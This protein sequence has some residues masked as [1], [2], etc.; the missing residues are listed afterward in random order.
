MAGGRTEVHLDTK[1]L[2]LLQKT[3][4]ERAQLLINKV[5]F[6]VERDAKDNAPVKTGFLKN[7]GSSVI[8]HLKNI[9]QFVAE[10][11][12]YVEL[13]TRKM[14]AQ[15]FL[16]PSLERHRKPFLAAWKQLFEK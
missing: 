14:R 12:I 2:D 7:S 9:V 8:G 5:T 10:Y 3:L 11:A 4:D 16:I 1:R 15:P 6:D 13:G